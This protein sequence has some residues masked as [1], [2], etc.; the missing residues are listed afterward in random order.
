MFYG[1]I[2]G[3]PQ[4]TIF[5]LEKIYSMGPL[6]LLLSKSI[7]EFLQN[8]SSILNQSLCSQVILPSAV[9]DNEYF[10]ELFF[11]TLYQLNDHNTSIKL[12]KTLEN[13]LRKKNNLKEYQNTFLQVSFSES[14]QYNA[15]MIKA[16][17]RDGCNRIKYKSDKISRGLLKMAEKSGFLSASLNVA[18]FH[19]TTHR[20]KEAVRVLEGLKSKMSQPS[21]LYRNTV[22]TEAYEKA[23]KG[24]SLSERIKKHAVMD[25][26]FGNDFFYIE[27]L[28]LEQ[29]V[30]LQRHMPGLF[31]PPFVML[32]FLLVLCYRQ[33]DPR[34]AQ[35]ALDDLHVLVHYDENRYILK[36]LR[37]ISWQ[38]L[39]IVNK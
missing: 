24:L 2:P 4:P 3:Y 9:F 6:C 15:F 34:K 31:I 13:M 18:L 19:Y 32:H 28:W 21:L 17:F 25:L 33:I 10:T 20:Y 27:E 29:E 38:I 1:K 8:S 16:Q 39:G 36:E 5:E 26:K 14:F 30:C 37:D 35:S 22:N 7:C 12:L 11:V 23:V